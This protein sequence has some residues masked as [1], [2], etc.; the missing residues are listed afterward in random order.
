MAGTDDLAPLLTGGPQ[1]PPYGQ[2]LLKAWNPDT[3][4]NVVHFRG[5]DLV[6]LP[7]KSSV[8]ALTYQAGDTVILARWPSSR[9]GSSTWWIDGRAVIPGA[10]RGEDAIAFMTTA[11]GAAVARS[12]IGNSVF[13]DIVAAGGGRTAF[14]TFG[15]LEQLSSPTL[16]P[17]VTFEL[18][19]TE[20]LAIW[21]CHATATPNTAEEHRVEMY[22]SLDVTGPTNTGPTATIHS[23]AQDVSF[24]DLPNTRT[25]TES[26]V[27]SRKYTGQTPGSYTATAKYLVVD[28]GLS[29]L[30]QARWASRW[31]LII[32]F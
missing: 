29:S 15:D 22:M 16:G 31:L 25:I 27:G 3:F 18:S 1:E 4:E 13:F 7:V 24:P 9:G 26:P 11:L 30:A 20:F 8:E 6:D 19:G 14:D 23:A 12:V 2:G 10:G 5:A 32:A 21:G 17:E 28:Q